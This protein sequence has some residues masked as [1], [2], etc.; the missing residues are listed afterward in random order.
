MA[1]TI[2]NHEMVFDDE[3]N[4][5]IDDAI[6]PS[7]LH[8]IVFGTIFDQKLDNIKFP[9][10][11]HTIE[12]GMCYNHKLD[13]VKFPANLHTI[14]FGYRYDQ[15]LDNVKFPDS[16]HTIV[17]GRYFRQDVSF[18]NNINTFDF[19]AIY[20]FNYSMIKST[21][22]HILLPQ[23]LKEVI[24]HTEHKGQLK[25]PYGCVESCVS[26]TVESWMRKK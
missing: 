2:T 22:D 7:D 17:F 23:T 5:I 18:L 19:S 11:L 26:E 6:F 8:T 3:F 21:I 16:L 13:G 12:F 15:K 10:S 14:K 24:V 25:L 4:D 1:Y 20:Q 9:D